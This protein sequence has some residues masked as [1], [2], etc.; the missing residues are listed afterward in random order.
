VPPDTTLNGAP[1]LAV[2]EMLAVLVFWTVKARSTVVPVVTV[3]KL[4]AVVGSTATSICATPLAAGEHELSLPL[5]STAD[6]RTKY[7]V[8]AARLVT[9]LATDWPAAGVDVDDGTLRK[10]VPGQAGVEVAR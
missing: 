8:P 6:T 1:A 5:V 10:A 4:V 2:P 7:V 9:W 3:P